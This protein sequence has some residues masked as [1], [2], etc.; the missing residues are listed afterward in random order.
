MSKLRPYFILFLL[1]S[2]S[3]LGSTKVYA[4]G[5]LGH[6][7]VCDIAWR[8]ST[9]DLRRALSVSAKRMGYKTF[10]QS[11]IWAD[12]IKRRQS[13][14]YLKPLH[15]VNVPR[16]ARVIPPSVCASSLKAP[17][18]VVTAIDHYLARMG[19]SSLGQK[20][21]DQALL[22]VGHFVADIHQPLHVS[23]KEDWGGNKRKLRFNHKRLSL[24]RLWDTELLYCKKI[25]GR[26][27]SWRRLGAELYRAAIPIKQL[28]PLDW[29]G[30]SLGITRQIYADLARTND[31]PRLDTKR[32]CHDFY[33]LASRRLVMAGQRLATLL[34]ETLV[35]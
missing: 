9:Q 12:E 33:P 7:V 3:F 22:L 23:Y 21:R 13:F 15:Y 32:Y 29:A 2:S 34:A 4:W 30:E 8:H 27:A 17:T 25:Q 14:D 20:Q 1:C 19:D 18:C 10:A 16:A 28:S 11:C 26:R 24:H 6:Q 5:A 35:P 31:S